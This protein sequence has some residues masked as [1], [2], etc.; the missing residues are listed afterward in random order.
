MFV[1]STCMEYT[2]D[3]CGKPLLPPFLT[4]PYINDAGAQK[5][6]YYEQYFS[7]KL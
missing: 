1:V 7:M 2:I 4:P 5:G 6:L 3:A